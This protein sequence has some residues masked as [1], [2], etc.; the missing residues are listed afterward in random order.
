MTEQLTAGAPPDSPDRGLRLSWSYAARSP[1]ALPPA[2]PPPATSSA[3]APPALASA[4]GPGAAATW[5]G[6]LPHG[7]APRQPPE[8]SSEAESSSGSE[9]SSC[10][11]STG[12]GSGA[13]NGAALEAHAQEGEEGDSCEDADEDS[14]SEDGVRLGRRAALQGLRTSAARFPSADA[15][16]ALAP[17]P[18]AAARASLTPS[19]R[20]LRRRRRTTAPRAQQH[21]RRAASRW[22]ALALRAN[23]CGAAC[24]RTM[25]SYMQ[26][27]PGLRTP[28]RLRGSAAAPAST[29]AIAGRPRLPTS[30]PGHSRQC[31]GLNLTS[32]LPKAQ[33]L[34][35]AASSLR[36]RRCCAPAAPPAGCWRPL[37]WA[38]RA[39][40]PSAL[41]RRPGPR[42]ACAALCA[43]SQRAA[44]SSRRA[45]RRRPRP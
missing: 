24:L 10:S 15:D 25:G 41:P 45:T 31:M 44:C 2:A 12:T 29:G 23:Q 33:T 16:A 9:D 4:V 13:A 43:C 1:V 5:P 30:L 38:P 42:S 39:R 18:P 22:A 14:D 3:P 8:H 19:R 21:Y 36:G 32:T 37:R 34:Q 6:A 40:S 26:R 11:G 17:A 35:A 7:P 27:S 28:V 20:P